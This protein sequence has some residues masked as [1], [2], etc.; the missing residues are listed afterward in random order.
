MTRAVKIAAAAAVAV[1]VA[2]GVLHLATQGGRSTAFA[3]VWEQIEKA[4]TITWK[5]TFYTEVT[6]KDGKRTWVESETRQCAYKA[7]GL[8][9][10]T[11]EA[12]KLGTVKWVEIL[13]A[14]QKKV[15][16]LY[17]GERKATVREVAADVY[18]PRG[19]FVW[20]KEEMKKR[21]L[22]WV[23]K[24]KTAVGDVNVFRTAFRD[25]A[26]DKDWSYDFWIDKKTRRL[27]AV[28][29]PGADI[30]DPEKAPARN[31]PPEKEWSLKTGLS[32][33]Q[34]DIN[35]DVELD[36]SLFRLE[37]PEGYAVEVKR[38]AWVTE[39][40]MIEYLGI[41]ADANDKTFLDQPGAATALARKIREKL[42]WERTRAEQKLLETRDYYMMAR[43]NMM[44][45]GHFLQD[46]T[47][48]DSF[49]Y[50]GKGVK[51]G[52]KDRIVCWYRLKGAK[53]Y[54][55]VYGDLSV[56]DVAPEDLPLEV[57]P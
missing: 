47:V 52:H 20:V 34:H 49:R 40:E 51:L 12:A 1:C 5:L 56:K 35:F 45:L 50:L 13:D 2:L 43:L 9:R 32:H 33:V 26:N 15:L 19:P 41:L 48:K 23:G 7:P 46:Q 31:N 22:E 11:R 4:K 28:H 42:K 16:F 25:E 24:K 29:V 10:V 54:R 44:P 21:S 37:P 55:A 17:P 39:K 30:Y 8:Y 27:V 53:T 36:A 57:E 18:D 14:V 3:Q 38:R 6:S